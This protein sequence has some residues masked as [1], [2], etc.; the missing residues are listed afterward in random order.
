MHLQGYGKDIALLKK[1]YFTNLKNPQAVKQQNMGF[2]S[3]LNIG[4]TAVK[5]AI[6]QT[7]AN[8]RD[9]CFGARKNVFMFRLELILRISKKLRQNKS[10]F[11]NRFDV[12]AA[13]NSVALVTNITYE[14]ATHG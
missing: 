8:Y 7:N 4:Y 3:D 11:L 14:G 5:G 9:S 2:I 12:H 10:F 1:A 6:L 13:L